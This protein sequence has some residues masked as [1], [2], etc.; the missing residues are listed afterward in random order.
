MLKRLVLSLAGVLILTAC[1]AQPT[2]TPLP[3]IALWPMP[4]PTPSVGTVPATPVIIA[5]PVPPTPLPTPVTY[6]VQ[7]G[8][9]LV[10]VAWLFHL[11]V[12]AL[13]AANP[14]VDARFLT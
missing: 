11:S 10:Y 6:V 5:S 7:Q 14:G 4:S 8:D 9:T 12:E 2:P 1:V 3:I 13:Q